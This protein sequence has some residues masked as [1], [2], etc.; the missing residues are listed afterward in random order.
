MRRL[1]RVSAQ[2]QKEVAIFI[3][4]LIPEERGLITV[5]AVEV[6]PDLKEAVAYISCFEKEN[7]KQILRELD[8]VSPQIRRLLGT[9]LKMRYTPKLT[10]KID[11]SIENTSRV[12]ELLSE[13]KKKAK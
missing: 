2:L 10:F 1:E 4:E 13:I 11:E 6:Q 12:E 5:T 9:R 8:E 3:K 7:Q